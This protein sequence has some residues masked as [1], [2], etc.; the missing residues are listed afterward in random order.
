MKFNVNNISKLCLSASFMTLGLIAQPGLASAQGTVPDSRLNVTP[1]DVNVILY[2]AE[3]IARINA[4]P[5][6][7]E[8][9]QTAQDSTVEA[10][11]DVDV[12][13]DEQALEVQTPD[14]QTSGTM[15]GSKEAAI[16]ET[17]VTKTAPATTPAAET[18]KP[19]SMPQK[20]APKYPRDISDQ[21]FEVIAGVPIIEN[22]QKCDSDELDIDITVTNVSKSKG[23]IVADLH[24]DVEEDFL[25]WDRVVL[26]VRMAATEDTTKFCMPLTEP[27]DYAVAIYHD[28]NGNKEFDKNF[29]GLPK[30][31]F[32]MSRDPKFGT[33]SPKLEE[34]IFTVPEGGKDMTIRLF[35]TGDIL[36]GR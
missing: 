17:P 6:A 2:D 5:K 13:V 27:G 21:V 28:K 8:N 1:G 9:T 29:L 16:I 24:N 35:S 19:V 36:G 12:D 20:T 33:K 22:P 26:R 7:A 34:T 3:T 18:A 14:A 31:R 30:E 15:G 10:D 25:V 32:G 23:T 4:A 11:V